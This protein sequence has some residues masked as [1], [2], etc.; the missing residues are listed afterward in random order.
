MHIVIP[1]LNLLF[2]LN[3][4]F[5]VLILVILLSPLRF[6]LNLRFLQVAV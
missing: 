2:L 6:L 4:R 3:L 5:L 1:L